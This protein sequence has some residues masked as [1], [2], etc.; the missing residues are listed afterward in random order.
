MCIVIHVLNPN[1]N[2]QTLPNK[3]SV[4]AYSLV[5]N[6]SSAKCD[7]SGWLGA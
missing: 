1:P 6:R 2:M 5:K 7:G 3:A 4:S